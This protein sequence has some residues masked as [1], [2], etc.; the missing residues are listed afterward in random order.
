MTATRGITDLVE[1]M[2]RVIANGPAA[3][4]QPLSGP[5]RALM[6]LVY[7]PVRGVTSLVGSGIDVV[8]SQLD[9]LLGESVPSAERDAVVA[10]LNGVIGDY[11]EASG[12]ALAIVMELRADGRT[13]PLETDE[14]AE[15]L[16]GATGKVVVLV[17]GSS[18]NDR[19]WNRA[20]HDHGA[21]LARDLGYTPVYVRYNSGLHISTNGRALTER[22]EGLRRAWPVPLSE[23]TL[24]GHSMGGLVARSACSLGEQDGHSWRR[25]L[26]RIVC[27]GSPH[28][29]SQ[30]ERGGNMID[31]LLGISNYSAPFARLGKIRSAGV[32]DLRHGNVMD[33]DWKDRDRFARTSDVRRGLPLPTDVDCFTVA[34]TLTKSIAGKVLGDGLVPVDSAL[35]RHTRPEL[36]LAFPADHQWV[37]PST[38]HLDLLSSPAVYE[39]L[40]VWLAAP[41]HVSDGFSVDV[42]RSAQ[43]RHRQRRPRSARTVR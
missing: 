30:L 28:H 37:A 8:L 15:Q 9:R 3:L 32:T 17:H 33:E 41:T 12:N 25:T 7:G 19:Q 11:L 18:M 1:E 6:P 14:L 5:V 36:S 26:R 39:K 31:V 35:G 4:G 16:P 34:G 38:Q 22:L 21:A 23:I 13:L 42:Q 24:L 29:G 10:A 20:G 2:H 40:R 43:T 27:L